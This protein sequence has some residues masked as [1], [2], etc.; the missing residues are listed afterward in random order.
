MRTLG[1]LQDTGHEGQMQ[2]P[3]CW[4]PTFTFVK[5]VRGVEDF[6]LLFWKVLHAEPEYGSDLNIRAVNMP[7]QFDNVLLF[8]MKGR[9]YNTAFLCKWGKE[10]FNWE[11]QKRWTR[12]PPIKTS[13]CISRSYSSEITDGPL[14]AFLSKLAALS[15]CQSPAL[16]LTFG[17]ILVLI[18]TAVSLM[19]QL[20]WWTQKQQNT[21]R[22]RVV[23]LQELA[24]KV[25]LNLLLCK[26]E[27]L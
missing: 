19:S 11:K 21:Q 9:T 13:R 27:Q 8:F 5:A 12:C 25:R 7:S 20:Y 18:T 26:E 2:V 4:K 16:V 1:I 22:F 6:F 23:L 17:K 10:M 24:Q 14:G 3:V 15:Y